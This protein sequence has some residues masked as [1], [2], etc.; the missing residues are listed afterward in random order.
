MEITRHKLANIK[1]IK[2]GDSFVSIYLNKVITIR[3]KDWD[4]IKEYFDIPDN[5]LALEWIIIRQKT[6][7]ER[8]QRPLMVS[9]K[10]SVYTVER[11]PFKNTRCS[12]VT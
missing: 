3:D 9:D 10:N 12:E 2:I 7:T 8:K 1:E 5:P 4:N 11:L 6:E